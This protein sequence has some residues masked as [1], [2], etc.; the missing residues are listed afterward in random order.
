MK[1]RNDEPLVLSKNNARNFLVRNAIDAVALEKETRLL[2]TEKKSEERLFRKKRE[3]ILQQQSRIFQSQRSLLSSP[4]SLPDRQSNPSPSKEKFSSL[5]RSH[6]MILLPDIH[7]T[8]RKTERQSKKHSVTE[9]RRW[10]AFNTEKTGEGFSTETCAIEDWTELRKCRYLRTCST[11]KELL[12][13]EYIR[14]SERSTF[15]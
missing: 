9:I 11:K 13:M 12:Y 7:A 1:S 4:V 8:Q 6:S 10:Q 2:Q 14:F 15:Q 3:L 5:R